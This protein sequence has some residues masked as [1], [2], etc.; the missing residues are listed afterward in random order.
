MR[1]LAIVHELSL[2]IQLLKDFICKVNCPSQL[3]EWKCMQKCIYLSIS[4]LSY[5]CEILHFMYIKIKTQKINKNRYQLH[6]NFIFRKIN[7]GSKISILFCIILHINFC[8]KRR[9]HRSSNLSLQLFSSIRLV[10]C[11]SYFVFKL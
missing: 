6:A 10:S 1:F 7:S 11:V 4:G 2:Y 3:F 8:E 5:R 9:P